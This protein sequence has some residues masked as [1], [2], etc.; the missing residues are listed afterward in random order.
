[1]AAHEG[2]TESAIIKQLLGTVLRESAIPLPAAAS[3]PPRSARSSRLYVRM[4]ATDRRLLAD[5]AGARSMAAATYASILIGVHLRGAAPL[6]KAEYLA[7]RQAVVELGS[8][9]RTLNQ[10]A[11]AL[12]LDGKAHGPGKSEVQAMV[13]VAGGLRDHFKALLAANER[14]WK[15][16]NA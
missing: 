6:P 9:G 1:M 12:A 16:T 14:S 10:I 15:D 8:I 7:F 11:R 2:A 5:R 3:S 13:K 4:A